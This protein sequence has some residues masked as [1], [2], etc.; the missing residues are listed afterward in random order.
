MTAVIASI[1]AGASIIALIAL[2]FINCYKVLSRKR[3]DAY[4]AEEQVKLHRDGLM[5]AQGGPGE[6]TAKH[7]LE[8]STQIYTQIEKIYLDALKNPIYKVTGFIMGFRGNSK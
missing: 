3:A 5:Q 1:I 4:L 6:Q 7:M 8:T 2:W